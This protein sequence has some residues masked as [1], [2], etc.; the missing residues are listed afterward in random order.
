MANIR[1][2]V[3]YTIRDGSEIVFRSPVDCSAI[4]GLV[5]YYTAEDGSAASKEFALT[6]AHGQNVGDIDHLFAENSIVKVILDAT[7]GLA[8]VQNADTNAYIEATFIKSI[9]GKKPDENGNVDVEGGGTVTDEQIAQAVEDYMAEN[10]IQSNAVVLKSPDGTEW[11]ITVSNDGAITA[12]KVGGSGEGEDLIVFTPF[13]FVQ[14]SDT[15]YQYTQ[16]MTEKMVACVNALDDVE[17][18]TASGDVSMYGEAS[19][20]T[21]AEKEIELQEVKTN[22]I[23]PLDVPFYTCLGNHDNY[24]NIA[25]LWTKYTGMNRPHKLERHGCVFLFTDHWDGSY[26]EWVRAEVEANQ[27][28]R[29]FV[30]AHYPIENDEFT[31]G[32]KEGETRHTWGAGTMDVVLDILRNNRNVVWFTGHTHWTFGTAVHDVFNDDGLMSYIVHTPYLL[33]GQAWEISV[34]EE[35]TELRAIQ[36]TDDGIAYLGSDYDYSIVQDLTDYGESRIITEGETVTVG[37][38]TEISVYLESAPKGNQ[39]VNVKTNDNISASMSLLTFT[40]ENYNVPQTVKVAG[41]SA[42]IGRLVLYSNSKTTV[43]KVDVVAGSAVVNYFNKNKPLTRVGDYY[44]TGTSQSYRLSN[45]IP[46]KTVDTVR[47]NALGS[48][49][50]MRLKMFD[51]DFNYIAEVTGGTTSVKHTITEENVAYVSV[52][53]RVASDGDWGETIMVTVN[54]ELPNAYVAYNAEPVGYVLTNYADAENPSLVDGYYGGTLNVSSASGLNVSN[55]IPCVNGDVVY[56]NNGTSTNGYVYLY[57][58]EQTM[59]ERV[60]WSDSGVTIANENAAYFSVGYNSTKAELMIMKN[61]KIPG[62]YVADTDMM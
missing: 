19:N 37:G 40:P 53:Y 27:G 13:K 36:F 5:V 35:S 38:E 61:Q 21:D 41:N 12:T 57:D 10:P 54:Q 33:S 51:A 6:D 60:A 50:I 14:V 46:A 48:Q 30:Y 7:A 32:L 4:T 1:V 52:V 17:F 26:V 31:V 3:N 62:Y 43:R 24:E 11:N 34:G 9:N 22:L 25:S 58:A 39:I 55:L 2:D 29:I 15:H 59:I 45:L 44:G 47:S 20:V 18:V 23:D 49:T 8:Y 28:K 16:S 56:C 42:G